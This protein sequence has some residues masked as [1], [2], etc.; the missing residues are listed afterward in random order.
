MN[1]TRVLATTL[2]SITAFMGAMAQ[3]ALTD[4]TKNTSGDSNRNVLM[5]ASSATQP[6][7]I[8]LGLPISGYA[9]IFED[10]LPVSYYNYQVYPYKSWHNGVSHESVRT[11]GPQDMVLKYGVITYSVDSWSKLAGDQLEGKLNYSV[12][13]H[14]RHTIDANISTPLG[15][16]WGISVGTYH[17][18]DPGSNHLDMTKLQESAHFYKAALSKSWNEGRGKAGLIYQ[19]SQFREVNENYGPFIFVGDGSVKEY[20]GFRLG[21]DQYRPANRTIKY[22][23]VETGKMVEQDINDAN[24]S[25]IHHVN[26]VMDYLWDNDLKLSIHSKFKHGQSLR[27]STTLMGVSDAVS[28]SGY[29]YED[30]NNYLGKVQTRRMLHFDGLEHSWMTNAA[31][32]GKSKD[33]RHNWRAEVDYWLN[34]GGV[35]TSMYLFAHEAKKDPK[36]LLLNGNEGF[37]YNSYAEYYDGH[38]H[39]IFG[40]VS[41]EWNVNRRLWLYGG[42]RLEYLNV[43]GLAANDMNTGN[44]RHIGFSLADGG[45]VKNHFSDNHFNY[46][47]IGSVRYAMLRGFGLQAEY[48]SAVTHSQLF[49][50]GTYHYP[51]QKG[52]TTNYFRGGIFWK[53]QWID[54]TSQITHISM[55]NSQERPNLSHVLTKD[56]GDLKAGMSESFTQNYFYDIA[57]LGWLTDAVITPVKGL[58]VH[59]MFTIRDPRYK[60]YKI[61]PTFSD[62]VTETYDF[63]DKTITAL[64]KTELEI[65]PSYR[66]SKWR[67]WL[68][69]RY[70]SK[71]YINK[72]NSLYFN[73]RWETFGGVDFQLNKH[74]NFAASVVN[75]LNQKGA[76]G[77]IPSADLITDPSLYKNYVMAGTFIRPFTFEFTT[78]LKL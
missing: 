54:L 55:S 18:F 26:F 44:A 24:T 39:K 47:F 64:S 60:N 11:M 72:T 25:K 10:G 59:L 76:S 74:I 9:Y 29:T 35:S 20:D 63:T 17:N 42:V 13:H 7:Q 1:L 28:G 75:I 2:L 43:R 15:K 40:L 33:Q 31:L 6:R 19:Y 32:T 38:E 8:S 14:G 77:S 21:I 30:G 16:G 49:H 66:F 22:L 58:S 23:D 37:S 61:T 46:A 4:S 12:N 65:E 73:G 69:A 56:V 71:Q 5:N 50:Y 62:G 70:F 68:S 45:V 51:T 27:S 78:K 34:H 67:V 53:N 57:T 36:L 48:S 41:D 52:M 3:D